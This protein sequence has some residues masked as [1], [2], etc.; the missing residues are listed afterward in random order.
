MA[1]RETTK[2]KDMTSPPQNIEVKC[3]KCGHVYS[4]WHRPSINLT[5]E[6]FDD[7]YLEAASTS[8]CP[9]CHYKVHHDVLI[10]RANGVW[11]L[12]NAGNE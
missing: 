1:R 8:I 12:N 7:E 4:D 5:L 10:V 6:D 11:E 9:E 2:T 3:P